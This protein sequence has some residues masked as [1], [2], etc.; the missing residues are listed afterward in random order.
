MT[1]RTQIALLVYP[2]IQAVLFGVGIIAILFTPLVAQ[3]QTAIP[4]MIAATLAASIPIA[5]R[6]A[7]KL[8]LRLS[9]QRRA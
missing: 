3:A 6:I 4:L 7:P 8:S 1:L 9:G 5:W 2:M